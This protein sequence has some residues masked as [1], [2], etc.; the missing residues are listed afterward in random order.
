MEKMIPTR[1]HLR[2]QAL[3]DDGVTDS[4]VHRL[5]FETSNA[6]DDLITL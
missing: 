1:L 5:M 3:V 2:P 6:I 4:A